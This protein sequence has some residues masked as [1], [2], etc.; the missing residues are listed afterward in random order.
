VGAPSAQ[1]VLSQPKFF[2]SGRLE[3]RRLRKIGRVE[4]GFYMRW[5][6]KSSLTK[7]HVSDKTRVLQKKN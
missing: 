3:E 6:E 7:S 5:R 2:P 4:P 1:E